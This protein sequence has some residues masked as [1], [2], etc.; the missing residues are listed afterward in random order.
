MALDGEAS[1][2]TDLKDV[3]SVAVLDPGPISSAQGAVVAAGDHRVAGACAGAVGQG[4]LA[5][6]RLPGGV[7]AVGPGA[8]VQLTHGVP[9]RG[10]QQARQAGLLVGGPGGVRRLDHVPGVTGVDPAVVE[11]VVQSG[12][13]TIAD[14][15]GGDSFGGGGEPV[16]LGQG[17]SGAVRVAL[18]GQVPEDATGRHG[19]QLLVV[20]DQPHAATGVDDM[21]DHGREVAGAGH[22]CLVDQHQRPRADGSAQVRRR[23]GSR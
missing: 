10:Q 21:L 5:S 16:Q 13:V 7:E 8:L 15:E 19:G 2:G 11:I 6:G 17:R 20:P 14:G 18:L 23:P 9:G 12:G 1:V 4:H 3:P 22:A